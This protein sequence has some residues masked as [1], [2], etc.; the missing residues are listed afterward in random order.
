MSEGET[1]SSMA[2]G[3]NKIQGLAALAILGWQEDA[4]PEPE[5]KTSLRPSVLRYRIGRYD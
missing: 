1:S 3:R 5:E 4:D 2:Q